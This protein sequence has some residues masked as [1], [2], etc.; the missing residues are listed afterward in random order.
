MFSN[1]LLHVGQEEIAPR[2]TDNHLGGDYPPPWLYLQREATSIY[3]L[4]AYFPT[5]VYYV[6]ACNLFLLYYLLQPLILPVQPPTID[7]VCVPPLCLLAY[8][9]IHLQPSPL[10]TL[11]QGG[12]SLYVA[13]TY[14][15]IS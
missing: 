7:S 6:L 10:R 4:L 14:L 2:I 12:R 8:Q 13:Y 11:P 5:C 9:A 15:S 3:R 1:H